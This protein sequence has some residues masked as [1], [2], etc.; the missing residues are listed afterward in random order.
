MPDGQG[1]AQDSFASST[2]FPQKNVSGLVQGVKAKHLESSGHSESSPLEHGI[3]QESEASSE[4]NPQKKD[5]IGMLSSGLL[6]G[7]D[8]ADVGLS[9]RS[10]LRLSSGSIETE[11][12]GTVASQVV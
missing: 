5:S 11:N 3:E 9:L 2:L 1:M 4:L 7:I 12:E 10:S 8:G 6:A